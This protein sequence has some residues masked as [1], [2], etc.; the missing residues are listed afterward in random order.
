MGVLQQVGDVLVQEVL[1]FVQEAMRG[2]DDVLRKV[3]HAKLERVQLALQEVRLPC[4]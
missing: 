1:V 3:R 4:Q 2:V